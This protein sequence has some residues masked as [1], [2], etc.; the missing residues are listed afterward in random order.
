MNKILRII[1][2]LG[3]IFVASSC[4]YKPV[5]FEK[6]Y[7]FKIEEVNISGDKEVNS[8]IK[9]NLRFIKSK[10]QIYKKKYF[11]KINTT[12]ERKI[13]SK[14]TEGDPSKFEIIITTEYEIINNE[15]LLINR[16]I[17]QKN[18][19]NNESDKFKLEQS[20]KIIIENLS[21]KISENIISSII[22]LNDN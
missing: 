11:V 4:S 21:E 14:D 16:K 22:N 7:N 10:D 6:A 20:E 3:L 13:I 1:I 9:R 15:Q 19:Y 18:I 17:Q 8:I 5:F 12:K 2:M